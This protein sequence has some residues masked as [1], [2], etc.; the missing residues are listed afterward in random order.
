MAEAPRRPALG[1]GLGALISVDSREAAPGAPPQDQLVRVQVDR[2]RPNPE[3]P[4]EVFNEAALAELAE[5]IRVHGILSPIV[6]R[7]DD[8]GNYILIAGERRWRAARLAGLTDVPV[9]VR[10]SIPGPREQLEL[11][12]IE[13]LQREDLDPIEAAAGYQRLIQLYGYTQEEVARGVG[14]DRATVANGLRLLKL[15]EE[16]LRA[17]RERRI[18]AG[19]ARAL[20][21]VEDPEQF[22]LALATVIAKE[23]SVRATE[24][25]VRGLKRAPKPVRPK[26]DKALVRLS[27][28]LARG[29]GTRVA[30]QGRRKGGGRILIDYHDAADLD[31]LAALLGNH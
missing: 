5:S 31:R 17:L 21:V 9:L 24:Q 30:I 19:H 15:P 2:V 10:G 11:A 12:L 28:N 8:A 27:D 22:K 4:R 16:G 13:N 29:L 20:V 18:T 7:R 6:V 14:K 25:L 1:R 26:A 23:L 3:Q